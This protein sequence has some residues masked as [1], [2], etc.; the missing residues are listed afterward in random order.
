MNQ[1]AVKL[2]LEDGSE[3]A[4]VSFGKLRS[5]AGEVVFTTSMT[6]YPQALTDPSF[7]GQILVSTYPLAGNYGV[8]LCKRTLAPRYEEDKTDEETT[9]AVPPSLSPEGGKPSFHFTPRFIASTA[10][11]PRIPLDFES[12]RIQVSG[13]IVQ[14]YCETPSHHASTASLAAWLAKNGVPA[15]SGIDTRALTKRLRERGVMRGKILV[16]GT[17]DITFDSSV[18][19]RPVSDV[20]CKDVIRYP[21]RGT[22]TQ[23]PLKIALLDCGVKANILRLLLARGV[24]IIRIPWNHDLS[25]IGYDGLFLSNGPGDPKDCTPAIDTVRR[26]LR[27][28][29]PVFGICLGIQLIALAAGGDTYKLPYGHRSAN[30]PCLETDSG[31]CFITSQNH[32]Y[33]VRAESLSSDWEVWFTNANDRTVEGIRHKTRPFSA[34]QFHPEGCPGPQ[35]TEWLLD[36]FLEQVRG[37]SPPP[38]N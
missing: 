15:V 13:F 37:K 26:A 24:E 36:R 33:A 12:D 22:Q 27:G 1:T 2:V 30:Q 38:G 5:A 25:G 28:G 17:K 16:E 32:G 9:H 21:A 6:G 20:S 34:V 4:G 10:G 18:P 11:G 35:D 3:Y 31:R 7:R 23:R 19:R 14:E 29:K 8:P